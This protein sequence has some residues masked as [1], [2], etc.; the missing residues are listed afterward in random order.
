MLEF[1]HSLTRLP[2]RYRRRLILV[3]LLPVISFHYRRLVAL[4]HFDL[5]IREPSRF[6]FAGTGMYVVYLIFSSRLSL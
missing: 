5:T 6:L 2:I 3:S 1:L 4:I